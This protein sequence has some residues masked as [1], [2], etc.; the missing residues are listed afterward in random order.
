MR[1]GSALVI[2]SIVLLGLVVPAGG[3]IPSRSSPAEDQSDTV[4][5]VPT[6]VTETT[7]CSFPVTS[8]DA[9]GTTITVEEEPQRI[10]TL[11]P[12]AAQ[13]LWEI[14]GRE[15]VVGVSK[16]A[17]YLNGSAERTNI[18]GPGLTYVVAEKVVN[19]TP[20]LVLAPNVIPNE[21]VE[22]LR[23]LGLTVYRFEAAK[24][25]ADVKQKTRLIGRLTGECEGAAR[26]VAEMN[27][28][29]AVVRNATADE[30]RPA[31]LYYLGGEFTAGSKTFINAIIRRA[32]AE[33]VAAEAGITGYRRISSEVV[34][35]QDPKYIILPS[36]I[37]SS[38]LPD[39][40]NGTTAVSAGNF[41]TVNNDYINQPA[42]RTVQVVVTLTKAFHPA[43][44]EEA[45]AAARQT[46]TP[47]AT[48]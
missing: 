35:K 26:T 18:S 21:T 24:S 17:T 41:V 30:P 34:V 12:S 28:T 16:Y 1:R 46:A 10:V 36:N 33:N 5:G 23:S 40:Y 8:T 31:V 44:Y 32:G 20:D 43:A 48:P 4:V 13:T 47:T 29:L 19:A 22:K 38:A 6:Q 11:A 3:T 42:P 37:P 25:M 9:T 2:A 27:E 39:S 14:G 7:T 45:V 15:K